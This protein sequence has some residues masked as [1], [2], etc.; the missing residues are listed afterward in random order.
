M[1]QLLTVVVWQN[2]VSERTLFADV[3]NNCYNEQT[4]TSAV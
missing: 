3:V 2:L 1:R 4:T